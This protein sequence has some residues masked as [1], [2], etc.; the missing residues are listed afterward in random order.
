[1]AAKKLDIKTVLAKL[2]S[3]DLIYFDNLPDEDKKSLSP[4][5]LMRYMSSSSKYPELHL[6]STN[7]I[8][9]KHFSISNKQP[10]LA[11]KLLAVSG[12]GEKMYHK[13]VAPPKSKVGSNPILVKLS[14]IYPHFSSDEL[15]LYVKI[16]GID[17]IM[18]ELEQNGID[19]NE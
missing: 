1:M 10:S 13:W 14:G 11:I 8:V 5:V 19:C 3:N 16:N 12:V 7:E 18:S 9:N 17:A 4:W 2:D 15:D 6:I